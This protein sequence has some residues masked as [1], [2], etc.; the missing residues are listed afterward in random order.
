[1]KTLQEYLKESF[2]KNIKNK[3]GGDLDFKKVEDG[4]GYNWIY[5]AMKAAISE[6]CKE[7]RKI[8][9]MAYF[10]GSAKTFNRY[11]V[12]IEQSIENAPEPKML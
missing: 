12:E 8:C 9:S 1:M 2:D 7:Q 10:E 6:A 3:Y 4:T 11:R 5:E